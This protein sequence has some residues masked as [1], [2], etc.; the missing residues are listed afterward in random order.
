LNLAIFGG[1]F[2]PIHKA[3]IA[4]AATARERF[5]LD[6]VLLIPAANPPHKETQQMEDYEHRYGMVKLACEAIEGLEPSRMEA[7]LEKSYSIQ[8]IERLRATLEPD[9]RL[10][11]LIGADAFAEVRTWFRWEDV[12]RA[13][14]FIVVSRPGHQYENPEGA[15]VHRMESVWMDVS[16]SAI[17]DQIARGLRPADLP[18]GVFEYIREH[19]LY[20]HGSKH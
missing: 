19:R 1:T 11:F 15:V 10:F 3:H 16:S 20:G 12:I 5:G 7:G 4:V 6:R 13:V 8:T 17:R 18:D 9:D 2:D 14:E